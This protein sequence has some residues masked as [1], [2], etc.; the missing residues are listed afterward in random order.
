MLSIGVCC[1]LLLFFDC[2]LVRVARWLTFGARC[3]LFVVVMC[4]LLFVVCSVC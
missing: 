3:E 2:C 1:L 4:W